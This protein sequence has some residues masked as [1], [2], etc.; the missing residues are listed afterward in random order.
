M[1]NEPKV[2][3]FLLTV[4]TG[5]LSSIIFAGTNVAIEPVQPSSEPN[6][7]IEGAE[8]SKAKRF[9][10]EGATVSFNGLLA[11]TRIVATGIST[12]D[13]GWMDDEGQ[14]LFKAHSNQMVLEHS[15]LNQSEEPI[16]LH[17]L[18][19]LGNFSGKLH[20]SATDLNSPT[21]EHKRL[22]YSS[23]WSEIFNT[24]DESLWIL[25]P[26]EVVSYA[27]TIFVETDTYETQF[28]FNKERTEKQTI[29][30]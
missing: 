18:H 23:D 24:Q 10:T 9:P 12:V 6:F 26:G 21:P 20:F 22:G 17:G 1:L 19:A 27:E 7:T 16:S 3:T 28:F 4:V 15:V 13:S 8:S 25:Q 14:D 11:N 5:V 2:R 30:V 29:T